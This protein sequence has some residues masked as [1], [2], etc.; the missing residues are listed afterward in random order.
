MKIKTL[1]LALIV[2]AG[3]GPLPPPPHRP[4]VIATASITDY[5][6]AGI[7]YYANDCGPVYYYSDG[8]YSA[9]CTFPPDYIMN[10]ELD[11]VSNSVRYYCPGPSYNVVEYINGGYD[12]MDYTVDCE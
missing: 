6:W 4:L 10:Y 7:Y 8:T 11:R 9:V 2:L 1:I 3:C 12:M 5:Y